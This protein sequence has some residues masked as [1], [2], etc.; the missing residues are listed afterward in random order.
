MLNEFSRTQLLFGTEAMKLLACSRVAVFGISRGR[1]L[2]HPH[3]SA[4]PGDET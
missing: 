2:Q 3:G 4:R 1:S